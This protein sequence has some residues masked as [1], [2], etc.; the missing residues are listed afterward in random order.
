MAKPLDEEV[1]VK[2]DI[3]IGSSDWQ[4]VSSF[5]SVRV[6]NGATIFRGSRNLVLPVVLAGRLTEFKGFLWFQYFE[7]F[8]LL[9][10]KL[11]E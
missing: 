11:L 2:L 8:K 5:P 6:I 4:L 10:I 9:I 1:Q 7:D 3:Y